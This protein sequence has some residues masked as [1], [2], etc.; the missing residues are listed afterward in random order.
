M[1]S[2]DTLPSAHAGNAAA[3]AAGVGVTTSTPTISAGPIICPGHSRP[4]P[5]IS[6]T[7]LTPD[8]YFLISAC[9][10]NRAMMRYGVTGDWMG[11]FIGHKG[12]VWSARLNSTTSHACTGSADFTA[13]VWSALTGDQLHSFT[14]RH[15]VKTTCFTSD[16]NYLLTGGQE[17]KIRIFDLN[18]PDSE[19]TIF[20]GQHTATVT[21][22]IGISDPRVMVS[23][24]AESDV[25]VW[26]L[27]T[28]ALSKTL[29]T[30]GCEVRGASLSI[31][32]S[33][34][35]IALNNKTVQ[36][37]DSTTFDLLATVA[38]PF[39]TDCI[40]YNPQYRR[41]VT[42]SGSDTDLWVRT[43]QLSPLSGDTQSELLA[44]NKGHH[45]PVRS[46]AFTYDGMNY[47]S[48]SVD[49]TIRI[50]QWTGKEEDKN[51]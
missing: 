34:L 19:P 38:L 49:G 13:R 4:V 29:S 33:I 20:E 12:A 51:I 11:S 10:D 32:E 45:G 15:I 1:T 25:R 44:V 48:G 39:P 42:G 36:M 50:W 40:S 31:D 17:K 26:D 41:L 35:T 24:G 21:S 47:A 2:V 37:Y 6:F 3:P 8:G 22:V 16:S 46:V 7:P 28:Q 27:R 43:Y 9:L 23:I 30:A 5:D 18:K 14:H